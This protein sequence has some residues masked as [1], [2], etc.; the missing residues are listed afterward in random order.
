MQSFIE[1]IRARLSQ[2]RRSLDQ[3]LAEG[4]PYGQDVHE[5]EL[6]DLYRIALQNGLPYQ[7]PWPEQ[8][9]LERL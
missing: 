2:E 4:D 3:A 6:Q 5:A 8:P 7:D 9:V 1:A